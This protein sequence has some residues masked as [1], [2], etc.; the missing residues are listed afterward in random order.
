MS[1]HHPRWYHV[2]RWGDLL[3]AAVILVVAA[4]LFSLTAFAG[5][6]EAGSVILTHQGRLIRTWS[7]GD[8]QEAGEEEIEAG[9]FHYRLEWGEGRVR[10]AE[11]DCPDKV[12]VQSGWVGRRGSIAAC[13]PGG[14]ILKATGN[15]DAGGDPV[16]VVIR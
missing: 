2:F 9:G 4:G 14:V 8:L 1:R 16:D 12:C 10:F 6:S 15:P 5:R 11:A 7:A 3:V 13:V